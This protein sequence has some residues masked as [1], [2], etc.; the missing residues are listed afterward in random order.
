M[1]QST[2]FKNAMSLLTSAVNV[3]TT[4]GMSGRYGFTASAVCSVTDTPPTLLVCMNQASSSHAHFI[5]NKV[6]TVNVLAAQ[7]EHLS[8]AFSTKM[9]TEERFKHAKWTEL[10]TGSPV[11]ED[12]LVSFDCEIEQIQ[13]VGTHSIFMCRVVAIQQSQQDESLVYFNRAYHTVGQVEIA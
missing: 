5:E 12:A 6:L 2:D 1:I 7:H 3:V 13:A 11:L 10:E 9:T 8:T 4:S